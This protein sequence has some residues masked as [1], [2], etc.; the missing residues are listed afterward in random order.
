MTYFAPPVIA[1]HDTFLTSATRW[2][3]TKLVQLS[4]LL[5]GV[6]INCLGLQFITI[7]S[8]VAELWVFSRMIIIY[9]APLVSR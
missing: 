7:I 6:Y 2:I 9:V 4:E 5:S 3:Y 8:W 1:K